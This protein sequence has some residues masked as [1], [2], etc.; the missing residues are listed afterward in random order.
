MM[1]IVK[2]VG[3]LR[4]AIFKRYNKNFVTGVMI[5]VGGGGESLHQTG[6]NL[7]HGNYINTKLVVKLAAVIM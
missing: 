1:I 3:Q 5:R 6:V 7:D 4:I 2:I